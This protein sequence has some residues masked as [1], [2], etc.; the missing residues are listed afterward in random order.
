VSL[1][2]EAQLRGQERIIKQAQDLEKLGK[3]TNSGPFMIRDDRD[4]IIHWSEGCSRLYGFTSEQALGQVSFSLLKTRF[5]EPLEQIHALLHQTGQWEGELT[6]IR[7][8]GTAIVVASL[9]I[10]HD[11]TSMPAVLEISTDISRLK[12]AEDALR[13]SEEQLRVATLAAEIG[14]WSW[15]FGENKVTASENWKRLYGV[16]PEAQVT[17]RTWRDAIHPE[18]RDRV[19]REHNAISPGNP[20]FNIEYRVLNP[21]GVIRWIV[22]RGRAQFD[23]N[24]QAIEMAGINLDITKRKRAEEALL[25]TSSELARSNKDLES[26]AYIASHDLQEPLRTIAGF[27]QLLEQKVGNQLDDKANNISSL[28]WTDPSACTK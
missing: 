14:V 27:L 19:V 7:A 15:K 13:R 20:E 6:H 8:D 21:D 16:D 9:W 12:E 24:G 23:S 28:P 2:C 10:L 22:D 18:D 4:R 3:L 11:R 25:H 26:F 5:P 17:F 1:V